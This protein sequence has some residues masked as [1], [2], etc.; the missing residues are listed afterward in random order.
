MT[1]EEVEQIAFTGLVNSA[2]ISVLIF[3]CALYGVYL[4]AFSIGVHLMLHKKGLQ[5]TNI[6]LMTLLGMTFVMTSLHLCESIVTWMAAALPTVL[7][8]GLSVNLENLILV[9]GILSDWSGDV[10]ILVADTFIVWRAWAIWAENRSIKLILGVVLLLD[11]GVSIAD[12]IVDT[13]GLVNGVQAENSV[14][15]DWLSIVLNFTVNVVG[16]LLIA[17]RAWIHHKSLWAVSHNKKTPVET[18]LLLFIESGA[19][20]GVVQLFGII[21][22]ILDVHAVTLGPID[23]GRAMIA[24]LYLYIGALTPVALVILVQTGST[25][26]HEHSFHHGEDVHC[27]TPEQAASNQTAN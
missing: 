3:S 9:A 12:A 7:V 21:F 5:R 10:I 19:I 24:C 16:T 13:K 27:S 20:F 8:Q 1:P 6:I 22:Q 14:T 23:I 17:Y 15:L 4:L 25:Y 11:I 26:E 18:V 2:N